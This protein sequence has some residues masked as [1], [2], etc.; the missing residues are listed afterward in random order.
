MKMRKVLTMVAALA[1]TAA[2][3][4]GGT[5]AYLT[6]AT[7]TVTNTFTVGSIDAFLDEKD[8]DNSQTGKTVDMESG[9]DTANAYKIIPGT[10][11]EKDPTVHIKSG[12]EK[13]YVYVQ[14]DDQLNNTVS[15]SASYTV[16]STKWEQV[17][18]T[19]DGKTIYKYVVSST[20]E[21]GGTTVKNYV[22]DASLAQQ[23]LVVFNGVT[24]SGSV[25]TEENIAS[26]GSKTITVNA[27]VHQS[28]N[29]D[30]SVDVD[31]LAIAYFA[32]LS[33]SKS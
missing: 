24:I 33:S 26:L 6:K 17:G 7:N 12:S 15:G 18:T 10:S 25:V 4:I 30:S 11:I 28:D 1:L 9:R 23:D 13:C 3:A 29:L 27:Y 8:V 31:G 20:T 2:L 19:S 21:E 32:S 16:D 14:I 22:V 5:L